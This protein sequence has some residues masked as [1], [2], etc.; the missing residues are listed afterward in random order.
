MLIALAGCIDI[1]SLRKP[2]G[3]G[4]STAG[5][6]GGTGGNRGGA[7]GARGGAQG[8]GTG[9][10]SDVQTCTYDSDCPSGF[11][12]DGVCCNVACKGACLSCVQEGYT[13]TCLP[14]PEGFPDP[15]GLCDSEPPCGRTGACDGNG[16]CA[17][18][19]SAYV[20]TPASCE[21]SRLLVPAGTCDGLGSCTASTPIDCYPYRCAAG[22]CTSNCSTSADCAVGIACVNNSCGSKTD[23]QPC[24]SASEC[25]HNH[26]VDG[27]CCDQACTGACR[28]CGVLSNLGHCTP[29]AAGTT[30]PRGVCLNRGQPSCGTNG[31]CDGQGGCANWPIGTICGNESCTGNLYTPAPTCNAAGQCIGP[32]TLSCSPYV[33]GSGGRCFNVCSSDAECLPPST[34]VDHS[35]GL[36]EAG[37]RCSASFEC[38]SDHCAQ[39]FCCL[40]ACS[41]PCQACNLS[42]GTCTSVPAGSVDPKGMC[43]DYGS[44]SCAGDGFCDGKGG[45]RPTP[46]GTACGIATCPAG[47]ST[48]TAEPT[49]DGNGT[50]QTPQTTACF[51]YRC[52]PGIP[53]CGKGC[54][55]DGDCAPPALCDVGTGMCM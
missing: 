53:L 13:G 3:S 29:I 46:A 38:K 27:F 10:G 42:P 24:E 20:C 18:F 47:S 44:S 49:C 31:K 4:G 7:G 30:D 35:C 28:M 12:A 33:C 5:G 51:P 48:R 50:C 40:T 34:C 43:I 16:G 2:S 25:Q 1:R 41:D 8:A 36:K 54:R 17:R 23:G 14:V 22:A 19:S 39:G 6:S 9:G 32:E 37:A 11:C 15:H 55:G 52:V 21:T 45:C 26:C